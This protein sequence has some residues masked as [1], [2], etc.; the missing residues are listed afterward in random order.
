MKKAKPRKALITKRENPS[1]NIFFSTQIFAVICYI[2][3]FFIGV[4][5][6]LA[7]DLPS[8]YDY[9]FSLVLFAA[10]SL[11]SGFFAGMKIREK[12]LIVGVLYTLP[13][14]LIVALISLL[15]NDFN[16]GINLLITFTVLILAGGIGGILAVN[17]RLSR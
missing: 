17:K 14:N 4:L 1:V 6:A 2:A 10:C 12:G 7:A 15:L 11:I 13:A 5:I 9:I 8:K 3:V 16:I